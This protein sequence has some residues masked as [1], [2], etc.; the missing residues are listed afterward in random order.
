MHNTSQIVQKNL[1]QLSPCA[2]GLWINPERDDAWRDAKSRVSKIHL[3]CQ[4][5]GTYRFHQ[6]AGADAEFAA[7][8]TQNTH[9]YQWIMLGLPRQK[10]LLDMLLACTPALLAADGSV[11]LSGENKAGVKSADKLLKRYF[12][13]VRK[14]DSARH[15]TLYQA[16]QPLQQ[17]PFAAQSFRKEWP[18]N[19]QGSIFR[20]CSYPGVFAHGRLDQGTALLLDTMTGMD[21]DGDVLDFA[22][23]AGVIGACIAGTNEHASV[24]FLDNSALALQACEETLDTNKL[25]GTVLAS[26]GLTEVTT[27]YDLIISNPPIHAGI[28][29][30]THLSIRLL[31]NVREHIRPAGR[32]IMVANKHL[33]YERW[34]ERKFRR[35]SELSSNDH[36][37]II[38]AQRR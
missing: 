36:F 29:T 33:P 15:C 24:S 21:I 23:G 22:C 25:S 7:F 35:V 38:S 11:W 2:S 34:L 3:F 31:D 27:S 28:K 5:H 37:K 32:L 16:S 9:G 30:D 4:D 1:L 8:P 20:I 6:Q 17:Q 19:Y 12:G 10:A 18:L 13:K 14:L 26:D